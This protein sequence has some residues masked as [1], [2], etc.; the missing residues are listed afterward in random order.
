MNA[1]IA[2]TAIIS[3]TLRIRR[4]EHFKVGEYSIVDDFCYFSTKVQIGDCSHI[5]SGCSVAGGGDHLFTLGSYCSLSS[6]VKIWCASD[7]FVNGVIAIFP[8]WAGPI[9][10]TDVVGDVTMDDFTGVGANSVVMPQNHMPEG[11]AI[12][13]LS[14]VPTGFQFEPWSV[15]AGSP[16]KFITRRNKENVLRQVERF[17]AQKP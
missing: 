1:T 17:Q 12:G 14:F 7:D 6:G 3:K 13:A 2:D 16:I 4:P 11:V 8:A 9:K 15:Y 5:A 10:D